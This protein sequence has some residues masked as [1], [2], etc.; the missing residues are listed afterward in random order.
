MIIFIIDLSAENFHLLLVN[1]RAIAKYKTNYNESSNFIVYRKWTVVCC[2]IYWHYLWCSFCIKNLEKYST[3]YTVQSPYTEIYSFSHTQIY[4][5]L[6]N[7]LFS[8]DQ[9]CDNMIYCLYTF[10]HVSLKQKNLTDEET[11]S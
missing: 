11:A 10:V 6:A 3:E 8:T 1:Q 4:L 5:L 9:I 2:L 7:T